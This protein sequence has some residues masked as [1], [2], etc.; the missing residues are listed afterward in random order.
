MRLVFSLIILGAIYALAAP[1][2]S[3]EPISKADMVTLL[4]DNPWLAPVEDGLEIVLR[5]IVNGR[6]TVIEDFRRENNFGMTFHPVVFKF[7]N[8]RSNYP[9]LWDESEGRRV[10]TISDSTVHWITCDFGNG[11]VE[12]GLYYNYFSGGGT[13]WVAE[14]DSLGRI[15]KELYYSQKKDLSEPEK[16]RITVE[17]FYNDESFPRYPSLAIVKQEDMSFKVEFQFV[18]GRWTLRKSTGYD[19]DG[20]PVCE[21]LVQPKVYF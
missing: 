14:L 15:T 5:P 7:I 16:L 4:A 6:K 10:L 9:L 8:Y 12:D 13:R 19:K 17:Y 18:N 1:A 21:L 3:A 2:S 20:K 11:P